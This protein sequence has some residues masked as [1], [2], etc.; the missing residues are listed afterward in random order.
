MAPPL[1]EANDVDVRRSAPTRAL[2]LSAILSRRHPRQPMKAP[3]SGRIPQADTHRM[4]SEGGGVGEGS[5]GGAPW[6]AGDERHGYPCCW[7]ALRAAFSA[8]LAAFAA[9]FS[10]SS[11]ERMRGKTGLGACT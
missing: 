10:F 2:A 4:P 8:A 11:A 5:S 7:A 3:P 1:V 9:I 6:E